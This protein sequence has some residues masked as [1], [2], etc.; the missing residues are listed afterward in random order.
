MAYSELKGLVMNCFYCEIINQ[1]TN[2]FL[3]VKKIYNFKNDLLQHLTENVFSLLAFVSTNLMSYMATDG[4][5]LVSILWNT[6][7][8]STI[9]LMNE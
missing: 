5:E 3:P 6:Q 4:N 7:T 1:N 8:L 2:A 9:S